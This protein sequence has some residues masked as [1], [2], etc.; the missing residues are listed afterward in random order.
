VPRLSLPSSAA[1]H[2]VPKHTYAMSQAW[3][4]TA[5]RLRCS[6]LIGRWIQA[7][8]D[9]FRQILLPLNA[10][11]IERLKES[12]PM[13]A[14][15]GPRITASKSARCS[16]TS[17]QRVLG[18]FDPFSPGLDPNAPGGRLLL[19]APNIVSVERGTQRRSRRLPALGLPA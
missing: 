2:R 10:K 3:K 14:S 8:L 18:Q 17:L 6:W 15:L 5:A 12:N 7:N 13:I 11:V 1:A 4:P 16:A 9:G 19:V